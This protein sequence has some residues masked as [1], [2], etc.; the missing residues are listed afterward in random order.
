MK[1][2][3]ELR[4]VRAYNAEDYQEEKFEIANKELTST[5]LFTNSVLAFLMPSISLI[6]SGLSLAISLGRGYCYYEA[7]LPSKMDAIFRYDCFF[8][9]CDAS[10]GWRS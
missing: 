5:N 6:M 9:L 8:I 10:R 7:D 1:I 4:V 2:L 3:Q